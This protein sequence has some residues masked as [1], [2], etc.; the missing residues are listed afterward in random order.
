[1]FKLRKA[2]KIF[3][4]LFPKKISDVVFFENKLI[5]NKLIKKFEKVDS[6]YLI[7]LVDKSEL[8]IRDFLY[9]DYQVFEQIFNNNEYHIIL[10]ILLENSL[11]SKEN[12]VIDAGANIG[13]TAMYFLN[14]LEEVKVFCVEPSKQNIEICKK[15]QKLLQKPQN[16]IIYHRALSEMPNK[17]YSLERDFRDGKDWSITT[18]ESVEGEIQ[19]ITI[20]EIIK[21]N[22]LHRITLLK[23]DIEGA[24]RFIFKP[25]NDLSFLSITDILAIEIHDEFDIRKMIVDILIAN[26][27]FL[28]NSGE[29]TIAINKVLFTNE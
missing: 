18:N 4:I 20:S 17:T 28:I 16:L 12:V 11:L 25:E 1:M 6:L 23:I 27:F 29:L 26:N 5:E 15:N 3:R 8:I 19:G 24:E 7:E 21:L 10:K 9:S 13:L 22:K 2:R 14:N